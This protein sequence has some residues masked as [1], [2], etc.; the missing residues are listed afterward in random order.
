[1]KKL[2]PI[3]A[4]ATAVLLTLVLCV[5]A[6][7]VSIPSRP[8]NLYIHDGADVIS[9]D[10]EKYIIDKNTKLMT[11]TGGQI[12]IVT[13]SSTEDM[14]IQEYADTIFSQWNIGDSGKM[15][16]LLLLLA[17]EDENYWVT[18]GRGIEHR[19]SSANLKD[20]L[21]SFLEP[22]FAS[23]DYDKGVS[24]IFEKFISSYESMYSV[25]LEA[26]E[27]GTD[28]VEAKVDGKSSSGV[29]TTLIVVLSVVLFIA[30]VTFVVRRMNDFGNRRPAG[31]AVRPR[32]TY[33]NT[34]VRGQA[35]RNRGQAPRGRSQSPRQSTGKRPAQRSGTAPRQ[36]IRNS[37]GGYNRKR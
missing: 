29:I 33:G 7:A 4:A 37:N 17:I 24:T 12:V 8:N 36:N 9:G 27:T 32:N 34:P 11:K 31:P 5:S 18:Q 1:M 21:D 15:N 23:G 30:A 22:H 19:L 14:R 6:A 25:D 2:S 16:G 10:T 28:Q 3:I 26:V 13:V 20:M 35:P